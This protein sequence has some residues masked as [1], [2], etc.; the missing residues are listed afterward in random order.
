MKQKL[1]DIKRAVNRKRTRILTTQDIA[2]KANLPIST[3]F[4]LEVGGYSTKEVAQRVITAFNQLSGM[5]VTLD[6]IRFVVAIHPI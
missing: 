1:L 4:T 2:K 5:Q 3:V 6:Q